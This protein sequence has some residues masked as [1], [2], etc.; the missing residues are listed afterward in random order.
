MRQLIERVKTAV[1]VYA[2]KDFKE[3]PGTA[4]VLKAIEAANA[5]KVMEKEKIG[6]HKEEWAHFISDLKTRL[7]QRKFPGHRLYVS[8][9]GQTYPYKKIL[10][11]ADG[12]DVAI[13]LRDIF[14][15]PAFI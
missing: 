1:R 11:T 2:K 15:E 6:E 3:P 10:S 12:R 7:Q 13:V 8:R 5:E 9:K 14:R 4:E